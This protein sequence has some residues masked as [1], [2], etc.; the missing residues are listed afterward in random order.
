MCRRQHIARSSSVVLVQGQ[1]R[2]AEQLAEL[3]ARRRASLAPGGPVNSA[4]LV[5]D[6]HRRGVPAPNE[7]VAIADFSPARSANIPLNLAYDLGAR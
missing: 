2:L 7:T 4:G 1:V 5:A 3:A 6:M